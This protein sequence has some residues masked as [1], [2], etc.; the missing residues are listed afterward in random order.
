MYGESATTEEPSTTAGEA[1]L[2]YTLICTLEE[3]V[4]AL[5]FWTSLISL[6]QSFCLVVLVNATM[7]T[8]VFPKLRVNPLQNPSREYLPPTH[9]T[10]FSQAKHYSV[11]HESVQAANGVV[12]HLEQEAEK[13]ASSKANS[14]ERQEEAEEDNGF[15]D[16]DDDSEEDDVRA[17]RMELTLCFL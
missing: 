16:D 11:S 10:N 17:L 14:E 5:G 2:L 13:T 1:L 8:F 9:Q 4:A 12:D 15:E 7:L 6:L 3:K